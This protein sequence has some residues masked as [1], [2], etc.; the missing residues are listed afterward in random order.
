[1]SFE[2]LHFRKA[3][4]ILKLKNMEKEVQLTMEYL[5]DVLYGTFYRRELLRQALEEMDW[6]NRED[7]NILDGRRYNYKGFR[8]RVAM[9]GSFASYEYIQDA[10]L[11][12][13]IG[14]DK[15]K[16]DMGIVLVTAER[17]ERSP[18]GST[19]ELVCQEI[20]MLYPTIS[21]PVCVALFDLGKRGLYGDAQVQAEKNDKDEAQPANDIAN[22]NHIRTVESIESK[23]DETSSPEAALSEIPIP[24][25]KK[26]RKKRKQGPINDLTHEPIGVAG[27]AVNQ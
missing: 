24:N 19:K 13:Q 4:E 6:R 7:L 3:E 21:L 22:Q 9:D 20:E 12:L 25:H 1:M 27:I 2:I 16:I 26:Q 17:S 23:N 10:L 14:F 11:R 5:D 18:L 15:G 8:K